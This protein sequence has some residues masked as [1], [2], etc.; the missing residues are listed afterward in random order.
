MSVL[1]LCTEIVEEELGTE[2]EFEFK[3]I[4]KPKEIREILMNMS[5]AKKKQKSLYQS[6]FITTTSEL[7]HSKIR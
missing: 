7:M 1:N 3:E 6:Q 4:P 2:E 5:S